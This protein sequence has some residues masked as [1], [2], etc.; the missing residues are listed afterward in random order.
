M[1]GGLA[2]EDSGEVFLRGSISGYRGRGYS[3]S[4]ELGSPP[5]LPGSDFRRDSELP[6]RGN[7]FDDW[8]QRGLFGNGIRHSG[9]E[10]RPLGRITLFSG[11]PYARLLNNLNYGI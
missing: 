6:R 3:T 8:I 4:Q 1:G 5:L 10:I 7:F 11:T 9:E 2:N